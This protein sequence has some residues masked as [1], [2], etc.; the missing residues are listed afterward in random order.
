MHSRRYLTSCW[1]LYYYTRTNVV[2]YY[3]T[4]K[5]EQVIAGTFTNTVSH[6]YSIYM[7]PNYRTG[8][9]L[10]NNLCSSK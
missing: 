5:F 9:K 8:M 1:C 3:F 10:V 4:G 6:Q 2:N 7:I